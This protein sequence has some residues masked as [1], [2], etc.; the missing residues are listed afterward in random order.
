MYEFNCGSPVCKAHFSAP[1]MPA[2]MDQVSTHVVVTHRV[3]APTKS[4][5]NFVV[6]NCISETPSTAKAG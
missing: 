2:L 6:A 1:S 5:V 3:P 4:L